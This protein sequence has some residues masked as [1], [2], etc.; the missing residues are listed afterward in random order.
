MYGKYYTF[1][2]IIYYKAKNEEI[3]NKKRQKKT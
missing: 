1:V 2:F 3:K